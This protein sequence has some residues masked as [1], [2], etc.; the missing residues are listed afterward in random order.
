M[1]A[2]RFYILAGIVIVV[3]LIICG[4]FSIF[5]NVRVDDFKPA[6]I[7]FLLD[8]SDKNQKLEV[9]KKFIKQFCSTLDPDD[10]IKIL[11]VSG[12]S[13]LIYEGSPQNLSGIKKSLDVH[14][15]DIKNVQGTNYDKAIKKAVQHCLV[16][17]KNGY[18]PSIVVIGDTEN[19]G[20]S[21]IDWKTLP[22]N[23]KKTLKYM[24]DFSIAFLWVEPK[25]LDTAKL[26]LTPVLGENQ[27][28]VSTEL[29]VDKASR[30]ILKALGR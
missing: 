21:Q 26:K 19:S 16:M 27:L 2:K 25:G 20:K 1:I 8:S 22:N 24:P 18:I 14:T 9:Q 13:Y 29:T 28:I 10:R 11:Q 23:I 12:D 6:F 17:K 7:A 3:S 5:K 4:V 15:K 30:K